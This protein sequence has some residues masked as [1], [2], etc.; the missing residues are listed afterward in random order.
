M[1]LVDGGSE[2][3][4]FFSREKIFIT[5]SLVKKKKKEKKNTKDQ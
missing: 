2:G 1:N 4:F 5:P 3:V